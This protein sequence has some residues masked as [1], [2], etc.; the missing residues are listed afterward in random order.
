MIRRRTLA[1]AVFAFSLVLV[2]SLRAQ[3]HEGHGE[4][5]DTLMNP[6]NATEAQLAGRPGMTPALAAA[7]VRARPFQNMLQ[8]DSL[9]GATLSREQRTELY[10]SMFLRIDLNNATRDEILLIP[11]VGRRM[12]HEFEEYRPYADIARFRREIGKY[13]N[14]AEVARLE[15][16]VRL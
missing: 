10:R 14:A 9:L 1:A 16:Y 4:Q 5:A 7:L 6:N 2:P 15:K 8:V 12:A 11:G 3:G 13:V